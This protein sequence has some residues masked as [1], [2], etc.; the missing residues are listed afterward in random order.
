MACSAIFW[1]RGLTAV[2]QRLAPQSEARTLFSSRNARV[3]FAL[4]KPE[5]GPS[6]TVTL[7]QPTERRS[8]RLRGEVPQF[9]RVHSVCHVCQSDRHG[10]CPVLH[11]RLHGQQ[12]GPHDLLWGPCPS[13]VHATHRLVAHVAAVWHVVN[14]F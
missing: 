14:R 2:R 5:R 7:S 9:D 8:P 10:G 1:A 13:V 12:N 11:L 3:F 6:P 4:K